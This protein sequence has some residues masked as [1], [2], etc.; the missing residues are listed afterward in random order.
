VTWDAIVVGSGFGGS[1][2]AARLA[3][4]GL[5]VLV[6]ERGPWW[7]PEHRDRPDADRRELPRGLFGVRKLARNLR[8]AR[9]GQRLET[10]FHVDGLLEMHRF[11]HLDALTASGVG[12]GSHVYTS[13]LDEPAADFY[14]ALPDE[15]SA[16]ELA[17]HFDRVRALLDPRPLPAP[18]GKERG[19]EA[20]LSDAGLPT[21]EYPPMAVDWEPAEGD[22]QDE[23]PPGHRGDALVGCEDGSKRTLD[24]TYVPI[25][26]DHGAE[27][28]PLCE[29]RAVSCE[30]PTGRERYHVDYLDHRDGSRQ[31][32]TAERL[33]LAAGGLNTQ[34]LLFDARDGHG[35]L[36]DLP[37]TLG[38]RFSPNADFGALL[39]RTE[40]VAASSV[41]PSAPAISRVPGPPAPFMMGAAG[42]PLDAFSL[43]GPLRRALERSVILF[44]MGCDASRG[45]VIF[46]GKGLITDV[47]R[48][49]DPALFD[50]IERK[51]RRLAEAYGPERVEMLRRGAQ[52]LL[53]V[54]P[55][56]GCSMGRH[57]EEG[58]TDHRGQVFGHRGLFVADGSLYP[59]APGVP[60]SL[61]IAALAERQAALID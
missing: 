61:T 53:T 55:L 31:R 14:D 13:L 56:G 43:P 38:Q 40:R 22:A 8:W 33:V 46:D 28:R 50:E 3:E 45:R 18:T 17:P 24:K 34:R 47:S 42:L 58:F 36:P 20:A 39:Y 41:G 59:R 12:G 29:V 15:L 25:A 48:A 16:G 10:V 49:M 2:C 21:A 32:V 60:P 4:R 9:E 23:P 52:G 26:L 1:V 27:L 19:F 51:M 5:A 37:A 44:A 57:A 30:G 11:E 6:L 35:G 54:H 7:G